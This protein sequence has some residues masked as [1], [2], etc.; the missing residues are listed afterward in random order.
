MITSNQIQSAGKILLEG[1]GILR[2]EN[3]ENI[4]Y[5]SAFQGISEVILTDK[6]SYTLN[7]TMAE[8][9]NNLPLMFFFRCSRSHIINLLN[10]NKVLFN[11]ESSILMDCG[12]QIKLSRRRKEGLSL[13]MKNLSLI[14]TNN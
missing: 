14:Y 12:A 4:S 13:A 5:F 7:M 11:H 3:I 2:N 8:L 10:I 9:E 1:S 6:R